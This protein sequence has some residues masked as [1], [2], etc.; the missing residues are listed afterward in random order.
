M[1]NNQYNLTSEQNIF[2]ST[3]VTDYN[4]LLSDLLI[5]VR[6]CNIEN[7]IVIVYHNN[8]RVR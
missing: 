1:Y 8:L 2:V 6:T 3:I 4:T 5:S 7:I